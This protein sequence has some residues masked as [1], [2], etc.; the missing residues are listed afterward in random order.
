MLTE[1]IYLR[2]F[3]SDMKSMD[4]E[5]TESIHLQNWPMADETKINLELEAEMLFTKDLIEQIRALKEENKIRMRWPNKRIIIEP[6]EGIPKLTFPELV[7]KV[8]NVKELE[9][10]ES[11][12]PNDNLAMAESKYCNIY[13]DTSLDDELLAERVINDLI[14]NIQFSRKKNRFNV[15]EEINLTIGT[16][17]EYLKE[18]IDNNRGLLSEKV[19]AKNLDLKVGEI[20][21]EDEA[22]YGTIHICPNKGCSASLKVNITSKLSKEKDIMCPYC[23]NTLEEGK[24]KTIAFSFL[25]T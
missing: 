13:L 8:G 23:N 17:A 6:K 18:Y 5:E 15:G 12:I 4:L 25:K 1:E 7:K 2:L 21:K 9:I 20:A 14:R 16:N 11:I 24:I 22:S 3:K 10:K 19:S